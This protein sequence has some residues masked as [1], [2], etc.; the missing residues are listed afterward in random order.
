MCSNTNM[1]VM[2]LVLCGIW[3]CLY[4]QAQYL[5]L[6][7]K[8]MGQNFAEAAAPN[9]GPAP[10]YAKLE[11]WAAHPSKASVADTVPPTIR[12]PVANDKRPADVFFIHPTTYLPRGGEVVLQNPARIIPMLDSIKR[13]PWNADLSNEQI[14]ENTEWGSIRYQASAFNEVC[15]VYAPRFRQA[16]IK[17]FFVLSSVAGVKAMDF[18]YQDVRAAFVQFLKETG[19]RPIVIAGHSQGTVHAIRLMQEFFDTKPLRDRLVCAYLVGWAVP[20]DTF[21]EIPLGI[22]PQATKC[23]VTW[24]AYQ[25]GEKSLLASLEKQGSTCVNPLTWTTDKAWVDASKNEGTLYYFDLRP[26]KTGAGIAPNQ[27][28]LWVTLADDMPEAIRQMPNQHIFD[29]N[30]FWQNIRSNVKQRLEAHQ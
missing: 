21:K 24:R 11:F 15:R 13:E 5:P 2:V 29:Y 25:K 17:T 26:G 16:H 8:L 1:K 12:R 30:L 19:K 7:E 27:P 23:F 6:L 3:T 28:I 10:D 20:H 22:T 4:A 14:N 9:R 18:A